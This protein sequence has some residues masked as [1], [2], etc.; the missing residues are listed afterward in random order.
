MSHS[1]N[2]F[3]IAGYWGRKKPHPKVGKVD[4]HY[5][6]IN[7]ATKKP[8]TYI[9]IL[10]DLVQRKKHYPGLAPLL[11]PWINKFSHKT[12]HHFFIVLRWLHGRARRS[13]FS[14]K[15]LD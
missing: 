5:M 8:Y 12:Q 10:E 2:D 13:A 14:K 1:H 3:P 9:Q 11:Q 4:V 7:P 15:A 6:L